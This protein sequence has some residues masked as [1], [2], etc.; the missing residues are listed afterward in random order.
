M[1][2]AIPGKVI[3]IRDAMARVDVAGTRKEA[4]LMLTEGVGIGDYVIVHAGFVIQKVDD[5]E[6]QETLRLLGEFMGEQE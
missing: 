4:S 2:I 6:A 3:E 1:C 5:Q